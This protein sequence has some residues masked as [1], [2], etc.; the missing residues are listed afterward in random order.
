M[1]FIL[2][3][4]VESVREYCKVWQPPLRTLKDDE[5]YNRVGQ[6]LYGT[7]SNMLHGYGHL[8]NVPLHPDVQTM[9]KTIGPIHFNKDEQIDIEAER[10]RWLT[11]RNKVASR[12]E[13]L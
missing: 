11:G 2:D 3:T 1:A 6:N 5:R 9:V 10:R 8:R 13:M 12:K 4:S 7:L